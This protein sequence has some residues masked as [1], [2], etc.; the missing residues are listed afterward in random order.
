MAI[1]AWA[2]RFIP[3]EVYDQAEKCG[4]GDAGVCPLTEPPVREK[5]FP[6]QRIE[7]FRIGSEHALQV[8][9]GAHDTAKIL[10]HVRGGVYIRVGKEIF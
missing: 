3:D 1:E 7:D 10:S 6:G 5:A 4:L 8:E 2:L 9:L